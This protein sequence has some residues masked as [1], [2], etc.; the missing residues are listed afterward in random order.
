MYSKFSGF[1]HMKSLMRRLAETTRREDLAASIQ[2]VLEDTMLR[3]VPKLCL[4]H[5]PSKHL[6]LAG[7]VFANVRL[8]R[9]L[10]ES[11]ELDEVFIFPAMGDRDCR[12][13]AR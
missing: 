12:S 5:Y 7:G 1:S 9:L 3:S 13:A 8:N 2:K 10:A 11:L 6:G 4:A